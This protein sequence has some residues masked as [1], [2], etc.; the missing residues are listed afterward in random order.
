MLVITR[1]CNE[2]ITIGTGVQVRVLSIRGS[3]VQLG[4]EAPQS[5]RIQRAE[6]FAENQDLCPEVAKAGSEQ[7]AASTPAFGGPLRSAS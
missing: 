7:I 1:K 3:R 2:E 6:L 4:I 5:V